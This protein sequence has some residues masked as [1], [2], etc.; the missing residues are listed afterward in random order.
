MMLAYWS[1]VNQRKEQE[2]VKSSLDGGVKSISEQLSK[3]MCQ[4]MLHQILLVLSALPQQMEASLKKLQDEL[5][6]VFAKEMQV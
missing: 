4:D 3:A 1:F 5:C 6:V 2:N